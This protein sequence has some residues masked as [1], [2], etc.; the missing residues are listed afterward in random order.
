MSDF[1]DDLDLYEE[2]W[3]SSRHDYEWDGD[4]DC[5]PAGMQ[6]DKTCRDCGKRGLRWSWSKTAGWVLAEPN[7]RG[8][9]ICDFSSDFKPITPKRK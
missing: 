4:C 1:T 5:Y 2:D 3:L 8:Y 7:G 6:L 9:H